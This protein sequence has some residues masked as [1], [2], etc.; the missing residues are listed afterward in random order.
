VQIPC[1]HK[2]ML[3]TSFPPQRIKAKLPVTLF[4]RFLGP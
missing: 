1:C 3:P 2:P 4:T